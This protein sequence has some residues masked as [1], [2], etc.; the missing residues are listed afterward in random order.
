MDIM[1]SLEKDVGGET[2]GFTFVDILQRTDIMPESVQDGVVDTPD[3]PL[4]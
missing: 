3:L 2:E 4:C 1:G